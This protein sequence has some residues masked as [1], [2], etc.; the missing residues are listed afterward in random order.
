MT[1]TLKIRELNDAFRRLQS[2]G[3]KLL[4]TQG[5]SALPQANKIA[6]LGKVA[7]FDDFSEDNDPYGEHDLGAFEHAGSRIF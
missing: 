1:H 2:G 5:I 4:L 3:G 6:I 7:S